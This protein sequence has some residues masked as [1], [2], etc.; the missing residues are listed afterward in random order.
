MHSIVRNLILAAV[1]VLVVACGP[2]PRDVTR[3]PDVP[4]PPPPADTADAEDDEGDAYDLE[5]EGR[6]PPPP[7]DVEFEEDQLPPPETLDAA[8]LT[9]ET[10]PVVEESIPPEVTTPVEPSTQ[11]P[12]P[13][14]SA[15]ET[16][17]GWRVQIAASSERA[18][19]DRAAR[20]ARSRLGTTA[21]VDREGGLFKV[22]VGD[23]VD[24][25]AALRLRD[26]AR[27]TGYAGAWVVTTEVVA[28]GRS[29]S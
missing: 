16:Q 24:R 12:A 22:R 15:V 14:T 29:G 28:S 13:S 20:E 9:D 27:A 7:R 1:A 17:R 11:T 8:P 18:E 21:Y 23:F 19:A 26:R 3:D 25:A 6:F 10:A 5:S 4:L 2:P